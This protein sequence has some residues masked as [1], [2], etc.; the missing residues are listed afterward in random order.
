MAEL[1]SSKWWANLITYLIFPLC[2]GLFGI[3]RFYRG[4]ILWGVIKLITGGGLFIWYI[5]DLC[6]YTYRLGKT[7]QWEKV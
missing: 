4:Q 6:I 7:G 1:A 3:D 2:L 5:I